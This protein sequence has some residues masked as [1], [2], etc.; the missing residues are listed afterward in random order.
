VVVVRKTELPRPPLLLLWPNAV[1]IVW[2][3]WVGPPSGDV[4]VEVYVI[5][6]W[7]EE[8]ALPDTTAVLMVRKV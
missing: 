6:L 7:P 8:N 2:K 1:L 4:V 5:K 3:V